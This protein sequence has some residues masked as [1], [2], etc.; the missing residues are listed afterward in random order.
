MR[1]E[2][3]DRRRVTGD[4]GQETKNGRQEMEDRRME[5]GTGRQERVL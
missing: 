4:G 3:G 5:T 1:Q 2:M